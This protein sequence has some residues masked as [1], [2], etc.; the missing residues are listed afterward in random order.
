MVEIILLSLLGW[1]AVGA[2]LV[3]VF[4]DDEDD[5]TPDT[6]GDEQPV[7]E[8]SP[9]P[10]DESDLVTG[11]SDAD[12]IPAGEGDDTVMGGAGDDTLLGE[13]GEDVLL[14]QDGNDSLDGGADADTLAG[15]PGDDMAFGRT[16]NDLILGEDGDDGLFGAQGEDLLVGG[17]GADTIVGGVGDDI[18]V[19]VDLGIDNLLESLDSPADASGEE[20]SLSVPDLFDPQSDEG[21]TMAGGYGD[22]T[23][24]VGSADQ[25]T[26]DE[27]D[28]TFLLGDWIDTTEPALITDYEDGADLIAISHDPALA[29]PEVT[30]GTNAAGAALVSL[31]GQLLAEVA[32]AGATLAPEDI[33]LIAREPALATG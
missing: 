31:N 16:G 13:D 2:L 32:G 15:G 26:G 30:I 20:A 18:L 12:R 5:D 33:V 24:L 8:V 3:E 22:D 1:G 4:D 11:T 23:I 27:G 29:D 6:P 28:D 25:A 21:D 19:G 7:E 10:S 14:G 17:D 9:P